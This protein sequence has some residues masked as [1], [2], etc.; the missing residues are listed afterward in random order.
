[1]DDV[2]WTA[3]MGAVSKIET[4]QKEDDCVAYW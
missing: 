3:K 4:Q 2:S 1:M